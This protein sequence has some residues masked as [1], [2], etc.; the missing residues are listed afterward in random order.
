VRSL[1]ANGRL[2]IA[3]RVRVA[4]EG[5]GDEQVEADASPPMVRP[6]VVRHDRQCA[7]CRNGTLGVWLDAADVSRA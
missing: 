7:R 4:W 5:A 3:V 6:V 2:P 1:R